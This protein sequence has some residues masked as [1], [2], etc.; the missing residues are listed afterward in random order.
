MRKIFRLL[1]TALV[2]SLV[3]P[4]GAMD[5]P[6]PD[7]V[8]TANFGLNDQGRP[9]LG[10]VFQAEGPVLAADKGELVF[11]RSQEDRAS[12][13]PSPLG[14][15]IAMDHGD[16]ILGIYSCFE[17]T[18]ATAAESLGRAVPREP[19]VQ[20][21]RGLPIANSGISGWSEQ[22]GFSFALFDRRERRWV[23]PSLI[24]AP[25]PDTTPPQILAVQ[26]KGSD[27]RIVPPGQVRISQDRYTITVAA[28]DTISPAS[29]VLLAP[30]R[31]VVSV[32]GAEVGALNFEIYSAR[33]G[34]LLVRRNGLVPVSKVYAPYPA[35]EIEETWFT[36]GQTTLEVIARDVNG[37]ERSFIRR[38]EVE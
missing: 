13:L 2:F 36:R 33:D 5:W 1:T 30:H 21:Q 25:Y 8:V 26:L 32:N 34:V 18:Q 28:T 27:N 12:G 29:T 24:I 3:V 23:I 11:Y 19:P 22:Q 35:F 9:V 37:N 38:L 31:L 6:T 15:W 10:T 7:G 17:D 4:L 14:A 16:G 20:P